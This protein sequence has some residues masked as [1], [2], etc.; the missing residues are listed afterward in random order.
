MDAN[1]NNI[2]IV[3]TAS[4]ISAPMA[5]RFLADWGANVIHI[6]PVTQKAVE[7]RRTRATQ[8]ITNPGG[9]IMSDN[10][11]R[12][13]RMM[14]LDL[15][16]ERGLEILHRLLKDADVFLA[17]FRPYEIEKF[18]LRYENIGKTYPRLVYAN[19][20]GSGREGPE[21][22]L[23]AYG[24]L[25]GDSKAGLLQSLTVPGSF[26]PQ[27][28]STMTDLIAASNLA[29]GILAALLIRERTGEGQEVDVSLFHSMLFVLSGD[30]AHS[31]LT[32]RSR[33]TIDRKDAS[34]GTGN[35]YKT[36]DGRWLMITLSPRQAKNWPQFCNSIG[37]P[38]L[39]NDPR[40]DSMENRAQNN[41]E[42]TRFLDKVFASKTLEQWKPSL[43][44]CG[45]PWSPMQNFEEVIEDPQAKA[46]K[47]FI[48]FDDP[49]YGRIDLIAN[50]IRLSKTPAQPPSIAP[51]PGQ[52]TDDILV[53]HGYSFLEIT[54]FVEDGV[55]A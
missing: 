52:H 26:P 4:V 15:S 2:T 32:G 14:T 13:K 8:K 17:N 51:E 27:T 5:G 23:P 49:T 40:F 36:K 38:E 31:I 47:Y 25:A 12:N 44:T 9:D 1:L 6:E 39:Q 16:K 43:N 35:S 24:N 34:N 50:P 11:V 20:T 54:Q 41:V 3:E 7:A 28:T 55:I 21:R 33:Q 37:H 18:K 22:D 48:P 30:I 42:L 19:L 53:Q 46:N 45:Y 10:T 29:C